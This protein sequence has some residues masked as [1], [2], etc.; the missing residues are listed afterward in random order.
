M[1]SPRPGSDFAS[2]VLGVASGGGF[3][4]PSDTTFQWP[5]YAWFIQDDFKVNN[6]LTINI[7]LRYELPIPKKERNL[8]NSNFC[9]TCPNAAAGG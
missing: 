5:Y 6:K 8:H 1:S 7:G 9:P 2:F 4:Y 3:R